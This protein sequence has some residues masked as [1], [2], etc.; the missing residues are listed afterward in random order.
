MQLLMFVTK[1]KSKFEILRKFVKFLHFN[2]KLLKI[3]LPEVLSILERNQIPLEDCRAQGYDNRFNMCGQVK[4]FRTRI[5][6]QNNQAL[7]SPCGAHSLNRAG[8][9]AA[10]NMPR[11]CD[12]FLVTWR[13]CT[14]FFLR[15]PQGGPFK[16]N[17]C[18][19]LLKKKKKKKKKT[20]E[21]VN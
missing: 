3:L 6:E 11:S 1:N 9:N 15:S 16:K 10:K 19:Y 18:H 12:I 20:L 7:L 14:Y 17:M 21:G 2:A 4:G 8:V 13:V 5:F